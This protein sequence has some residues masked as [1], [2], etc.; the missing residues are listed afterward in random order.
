[1]ASTTI[2]K[3]LSTR[4]AEVGSR[5]VMFADSRGIIGLQ[6]STIAC[7][8]CGSLLN[9]D[10]RGMK[11]TCSCDVA[12]RFSAR[13]RS[14]PSSPLPPSRSL[15]LSLFRAPCPTIEA[16]RAMWDQMNLIPGLRTPTRASALLHN[17]ISISHAPVRGV[18]R[19]FAVP[20]EPSMTSASQ[21]D[22]EIPREHVDCDFID[23]HSR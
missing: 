14:S 15:F 16:I 20:L 22:G 13:R 5:R 7:A 10:S 9:V 18:L 6:L 17:I 4:E 8:G 23:D 21:A 11:P 12:A 1:M 2:H 19:S 3:T